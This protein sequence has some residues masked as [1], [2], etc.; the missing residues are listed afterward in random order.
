VYLSL[1]QWPRTGFLIW[2][3]LV[4]CQE[5]TL[6]LHLLHRPIRLF[7]CARLGGWK[8]PGREWLQV[9]VENW[10]FSKKRWECVFKSKG[11][12]GYLNCKLVIKIFHN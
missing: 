7:E 4:G 12:G 1:W 6:H 5:H 8:R 9:W 3:W 10:P 2:N 11:A